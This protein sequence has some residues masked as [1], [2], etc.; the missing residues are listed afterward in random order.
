MKVPN[1]IFFPLAVSIIMIGIG[2]GI[3]LESAP[4]TLIVIGVLG[5]LL[6]TVP[7][8]LAY[9]GKIIFTDRYDR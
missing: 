9:K 6:F 7:F 2:W 8:W 3:F 4:A 1:W 5:L